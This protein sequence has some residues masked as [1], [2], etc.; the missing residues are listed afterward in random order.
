MKAPQLP[1]PTD[2]D[3]GHPASTPFVLHDGPPYANGR[4]HMGHA[5]NKLLKDMVLRDRRRQNHH[6]PFLPNWDCHGL[7][8][9]SKFQ[10]RRDDFPT[11]R[12]YL[13]ALRA[14]ASHWAQVQ[15]E[16]FQTLGVAYDC[17]NRT[18]SSDPSS[19]ALVMSEFHRMVK[20][21]LVYRRE[22][23]VG[24]SPMD[25]TVLADAE[26]VD[27]EVQVPTVVAAFPLAWDLRDGPAALAVW[28]TTPWSLPGNAGVAWNPAAAY[29]LYD[30][31]GRRA[32]CADATAEEMLPGAARVRDVAASEL[33]GAVPRHP[34]HE[35]GYPLTGVDWPLVS[36]PF[37][38]ADKG[39]GFVHLGPSHS[40]DDWQVWERP[41]PNVVGED[42]RY[43]ADVP[44]FA[45]MQ[46]VE[47]GVMGEADQA[48]LEA[49]R[50]ADALLHEDRRVMTLKRSWR[51][52]GLLVTRATPQWFVD[53]TRARERA[54]AAVEAGEVRM[55]PESSRNRFLSML[56]TRPDWLVSRQ[57][58][59]GVPLGL[60]VHRGT[61]AVLDDPQVMAAA[62]ADVARDGVTAWLDADPATH[63]AAAGRT[64][65]ADWERTTDVL[66]VWFDSAC[67]AD[68]GQ[69]PADLVVEGTDQHRGWFSST[70]LKACA[71]GDPLPFK[72]VLTHGF[73]L[74]DAREK[75][76]KSRGNGLTPEEAV[77]VHGPDVLRLWVALVDVTADMPFGQLLL[78]EARTTRDKMRNTLR[79][80][81]GVL[82]DWSPADG[83]F[84]PHD[85]HDLLL[86]AETRELAEAMDGAGD[87]YDFRRQLEL[88][89]EFLD[90]RLSGHHLDVR[91]DRLYCDAGTPSWHA[92][93]ATLMAVYA[94]VL[95]LLEPLTPTLVAEM[96]AALPVPDDALSARLANPKA[97]ELRDTLDRAEQEVDRLHRLTGVK[98][99]DACVTLGDG[100]HPLMGMAPA[101]RV[102]HWLKVDRVVAGDLSAME[103]VDDPLCVRCRRHEPH[104]EGRWC[105]RCEDVTGV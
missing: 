12:E 7:P 70:L 11:R 31:A 99:S 14:E 8:L 36:A 26:S 22:R 52:E 81:T 72:T 25:R 94:E 56:R 95:D 59:W 63:F 102:A 18:L 97:L 37:V 20:A 3:P 21:G 6:A 90:H 82:R 33:E 30:L 54:V 58:E 49:L 29:G 15:H 57:R 71:L 73:V 34:L 66:D 91:K 28:T 67:V 80:M 78:D 10:H 43:G 96:R 98:R 105:A 65:H 55:L 46:V 13:A 76:A 5:L 79:Y 41:Y 2:Y 104:D 32:V 87:R 101:E 27:V 92:T 100:H 69:G 38:D 75:M 51:S 77:K 45:G 53:L 23:P 89:R 85:P 35:H 42:G 17:S 1:A 83:R 93:R 44:L 50:E 68:Y 24:W 16:G 48:V 88:V 74:D 61:G 4:L 60:Y 47:G 40:L 103:A 9:E 19:E 64:D 84:V 86:L 39:T 62:V